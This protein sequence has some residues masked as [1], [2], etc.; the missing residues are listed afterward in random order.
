MSNWSAGYVTDVAY[1]PGHYAE[2]SPEFIRLAML[3]AGCE[4]PALG[5][6]RP[7]YCELGFGYG[8]GLAILAATHPHMQFWGTDFLPE[9]VSF[10]RALAQ[11]WCDNLHLHDDSFEQFASRATPQFDFIALHGIWSWV[12]PAN[13][14]AILELI[15][16]RLKVGGAVYVSYNALPGSHLIAPLRGLLAA[17]AG[18]ASPAGDSAIAKVQRAVAT[19]EQMA[20]N[21]ALSL[22]PNGSLMERLRSLKTASPS[23]VA[24]E[25]LN[26]HWQ[27]LSFAEVAA[28]MS[29]AKLAY[30]G[31]SR[32]LHMLDSVNL[33]AAAQQHLQTIGDPNLR[34]TLRDHYMNTGFRMDVYTRG[35]RRLAA[36][37]RNRRLDEVA[38]VA[39]TAAAE[40]NYVLKTALGETRMHEDIYRPIVERLVQA[41]AQ[42][43]TVAE[44]R[45]S[46]GLSD[47]PQAATLEA[48][49][50]LIAA[51]AAFPLVDRRAPPAREPVEALNR[52]LDE[53]SAEG[54]ALNS[55]A[56]PVSRNGHP[57]DGLQALLLHAYRGGLREAAALADAVWAS[58][59]R[60]EQRA[61]KDGKTLETPQENLAHIREQAQ[62]FL[63]Q[64]Y[65]RFE[66]LGLL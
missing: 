64:G 21:G 22:A 62:K 48:A 59:Q 27:P 55:R 57:V 54:H 17:H 47:K 15:G 14:R 39:V 18:S 56:S 11:G 60:C 31:S 34:E 30:A 38:L 9:Q 45:A 5:E 20:Q 19:A 43:L 10:A 53:W 66:V 63:A 1:L 28:A 32:V 33:S 41:G 16:R 3:L 13:Q 61:I 7:A 58:M 25:Y 51:G 12:S 50:L 46:P 40:V 36:L 23:Y 6:A 49:C 37:E 24:H 65:R 4:P 42:G 8:L 26:A 35:A 52:R 2:Q 44:L 29:E